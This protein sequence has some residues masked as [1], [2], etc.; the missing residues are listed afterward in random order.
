MA[1]GQGPFAA[2][3]AVILARFEWPG[4]PGS[5]AVAPL[6]RDEERRFDAGRAIYR[7]VCVG[8]HQSDGRGQERIAPPLLNSRLA[9]AAP[10]IGA[11]ILLHGK[12]GPAGL[13]PP[14][15]SSMT[16]GD[17]AAVLTY[18]RREWGHTASAVEAAAV[19]ATRALTA[20]RTR[21]WTDDELLSLEKEI[22]QP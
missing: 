5:T 13:M 10:D 19:A 8:C 14:V 20:G 12:E 16:D 11:R 1:A 21:P 15:G 7:N 2:R 9:L 6:T 18:V 17:L 3:A 22:K 4:K